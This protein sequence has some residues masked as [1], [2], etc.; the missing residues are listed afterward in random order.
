MP[1]SQQAQ[2]CSDAAK[3]GNKLLGLCGSPGQQEGKTIFRASSI[4]TSMI[5]CP[6]TFLPLG[7]RVKDVTLY[8]RGELL[9]PQ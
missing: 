7:L 6:R 9:S 8:R 4:T 3:A 1:Q 5:T 2:P